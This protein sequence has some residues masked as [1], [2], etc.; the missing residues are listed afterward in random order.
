MRIVATGLRFPE[1]PIAM[2]DGT[3]LVV[4]IERGTL[5]RVHT[6]GRLE[7]VSEIGGAP[8]GAALGPD[9]RVYVCNSGGYSWIRDGSGLRPGRQSKDYQG[10]GIDVVDLATGKSE[11]L[12]DHC[13]EYPLKGPNDIV[14]D[15]HGGFWFTDLGKLRR[16]ELDLGFVY[17]A[18]ADGSEIREVIR[19]MITPNGI[20]LS[21]DGKTL[22]VA[23]TIPG[24]LW[25][26]EIVAPGEVRTRPWPSSYGATFVGSGGGPVRFD[27]L[28]VTASGNICVAAIDACAILEM[29]RDGLV[30]RR[31]S[32]PDLVVTNLCFGGP[33][34][35]TAYVTLSFQGQLAA[36]DWPEPGLRLHHADAAR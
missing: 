31:H 10:G 3:V 36:L 14:F 30:V 13:G 28:A 27:S 25:S 2:A 8:N 26:W 33:D 17:W 9:G 22:Y 19:G 12:Y 29:N 24:R 21:P 35:R 18:R 16:R 20:G 11:R 7:V 32:V 5:T 1:G 34:L 23:E 4:E 15:G 6:D